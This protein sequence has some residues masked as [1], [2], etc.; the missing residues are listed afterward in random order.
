MR[1]PFTSLFLCVFLIS[2]CQLDTPN[3]GGKT[4]VPRESAIV[5]KQELPLDFIP[6]DFKIVAVGDSLTQGV[7]D[8]SD[9]GGYVPYLEGYL[10]ENKAVQATEFSNY[11]VKG[12]RTT[13][14]LERLQKKEVKTD[15]QEADLVIMT[16]GGN[17]VMKVVRENF[18]SLELKD[19]EKEK[20]AY[21]KNLKKVLDSVRENNPNSVIVLVG[22]Y[23]PFSQW[24]ADVKEIDQIIEDWNETSTT[25]LA[26]YENTFF[27]EID[28]LF[29]E[30]GEAIL[31]T[32]YFHPNDKG[33]E[34]M[35]QRLYEKLGSEVLQKSLE[36]KYTALERGE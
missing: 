36:V 5:S 19:F 18:S 6:K 31:F 7:G 22:L 21:E 17:D 11:G 33:Y 14:L 34:L 1:L 13:Q 10:K 32:D 20:I 12:N 15:I 8:S 27:V 35:A 24:F 2:A 25:I 28:D 16:I 29:K 30:N 23:N 9:R 4:N 3:K 26:T